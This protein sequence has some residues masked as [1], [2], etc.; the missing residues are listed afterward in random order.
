MAEPMSADSFTPYIGKAV[1][2]PDGHELTLVSVDQRSSP[3]AGAGPAFSLV[4]RGA[5][6]PI[7]P[8]GLH[9]LTFAD[10]ASYELYLIPIHTP[11]HDHQDYQIVFN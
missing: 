3:A 11:A 5:P 6:A 2:L 1:S 7:V 9:R 4:L 8:E 10:S